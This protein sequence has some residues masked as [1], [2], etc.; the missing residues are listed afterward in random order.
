MTTETVEG[1][2]AELLDRYEE[3]L[4]LLV[5][6]GWRN[7]AR[8]TTCAKLIGRQEGLELALSLLRSVPR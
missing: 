5:R 6:G 3:T 4:R 2:E 1:V 8:S 7:P